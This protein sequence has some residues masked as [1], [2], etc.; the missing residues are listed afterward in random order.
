MADVQ[1]RE[2]VEGLVLSLYP[3]LVGKS[4]LK[5]HTITMNIDDENSWGCILVKV[6]NSPAN[7]VNTLMI[8]VSIKRDN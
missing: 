7:S 5:Q 6:D 4:R 8:D 3:K 2:W 1:E